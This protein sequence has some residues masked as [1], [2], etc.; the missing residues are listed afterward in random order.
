MV[1]ARIRELETKLALAE[2]IDPSKFTG[3]R[4]LFGAHVTI[5]DLETEDEVTYQIVGDDEAD[6][7]NGTISCFSPIARALIGREEG[8]EC[9]IKA[10]RG[11]RKVEI[12]EVVFK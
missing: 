5:L 11:D 2:V 7:D 10:P 9:T 3:H 4:V 1:E 12:V 6:L 8:D